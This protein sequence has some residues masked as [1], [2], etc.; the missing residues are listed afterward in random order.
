MVVFDDTY[1]ATTY[2][3]GEKT[4]E[5][6]YGSSIVNN[7]NCLRIGARGCSSSSSYIP[8]AFFKGIIDDI[9][10]YNRVLSKLEIQAVLRY[11][12]NLGDNSSIP[13]DDVPDDDIDF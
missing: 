10:I 1:T 2:I 9:R 8:S 13:I 11:G 4:N 7:S 3:N 6:K 5:I 12:I